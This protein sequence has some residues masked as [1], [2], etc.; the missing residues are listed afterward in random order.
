MYKGPRIFDSVVLEIRWIKNILSWFSGT[1]DATTFLRGDLT[2]ASVGGG[3]T[4]AANHES[5]GS[6]SVN[7]KNLGGY[8]G[9]TSDFLRA[10]GTFAAPPGGTSDHGALT[11]LGDDDH[12]QYQLRSEKNAASGYAGLSAGSKLTGSQ[13]M[14]GSASNTACEGNDARLSD[15][16]TPTAHKASH[17][18]AGSDAL[19]VRNLAGFPGGTTDFL[20]ADATFSAPAIAAHASSHYSAGSDALNVKN[21]GGYPGGTTTFLRADGQFAAPTASDPW[22]YLVV[23]SAFNVSASTA[24]NVPGWSLSPSANTKYEFEA[25]IMLRTATATV[26]A[27]LGIDWPTGMTDGVALIY[28]SQSATAQ[29]TTFGSTNA[30]MLVA[31]GGL[32]NNTTSWPAFLKG[33]IDAGASPTDSLKIQLASETAGTNVTIRSGSFF[34]YRT[35]S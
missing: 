32:G 27:R 7:I 24:I 9:G 22:T 25:F 12:T 16:R 31:V 15:A 2:F 23:S 34:K 33:I 6:D 21:L 3:G 13:Q 29:L 26:N 18:S 28:T 30:T 35:Y 4:H 19:S 5:A 20:R 1:K 17:E 14:Y 11:G 8:P 10:D